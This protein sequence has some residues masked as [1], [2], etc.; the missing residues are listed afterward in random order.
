MKFW[1]SSALIP[2]CID[3]PRTDT[4]RAILK[5]DSGL[6]VW[7]G[8]DVECR[9]AFARL[10]REERISGVDETRL[11]A[12]LSVLASS[13]HEIQPVEE[14]RAIAGEVLLRHPLRAADSFQLAAAIAW[15]ERR[16]PGY[17]FVCLDE[18]L[19]EAARAEGFSVLPVE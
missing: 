7:W 14:V 4:M 3:E 16:A 17:D 13:W 2:L 5:K 9:S 15:V 19:R 6:I 11:R 18:R 10:K 8:T 12:V 1:D